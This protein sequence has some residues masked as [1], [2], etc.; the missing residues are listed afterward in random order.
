[1]IQNLTPE[2]VRLGVTPTLWWNDDFPS[3]DIGTPFGPCVSE[4]ALAGF[5]GVF[6]YLTISGMEQQTISAFEEQL[7]F[8]KAMGGTDLVVAE[9]GRSAPHPAGRPVRQPA[10]L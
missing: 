1:M 4:M 5:S 7:A 3:I 2:R 10:G 8:V 6:T 9:F